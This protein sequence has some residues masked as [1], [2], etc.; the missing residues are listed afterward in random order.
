M[1]KHTFRQI[2]HQASFPRA[3]RGPQGR[4]ERSRDRRRD[5]AAAERCRGSAVWKGGVGAR[6]C[7]T[8][9]AAH[10]PDGPT[11]GAPWGVFRL[12][13]FECFKFFP[14][15]LQGRGRREAF[16]AGDQVR[17]RARGAPGACRGREWGAAGVGSRRRGAV[18]IIAYRACVRSWGG[19]LPGGEPA[20]APWGTLPALPS[21]LE[22]GSDSCHPPGGWHCPRFLTPGRRL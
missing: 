3:V 10:L 14:P 15:A 20:G 6:D 5:R 9:G 19:G 13:W 16:G 18:W 11:P 17:P 1:R 12:F 22:P 8:R 21:R 7:G 4:T 2:R